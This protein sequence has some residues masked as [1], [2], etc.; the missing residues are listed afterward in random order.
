MW[1]SHATRDSLMKQQSSKSTLIRLLKILAKWVLKKKFKAWSSWLDSVSRRLSHAK[2]FWS[3]DQSPG[4]KIQWPRSSCKFLKH[5]PVDWILCPGDWVRQKLFEVW[6]SCL[7]TRS[8][9]LDQAVSFQSMIQSTGY[10]VQAT[11][12]CFKIFYMITDG[13][14]HISY[15]RNDI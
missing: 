13:F 6:I 8:S 10:C 12:S 5:I 1:V 2:T 15:G 14:G 4:H 3:L 11:G 7:D 9:G